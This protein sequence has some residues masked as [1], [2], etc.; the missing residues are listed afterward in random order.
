MLIGL[1]TSRVIL[2]TLGIEDF[3]LYN[4]VG[5][6]VMM[7]S[8]FNAAMSSASARFITYELGVGNQD[9]LKRIF[10][11]SSTLHFL[12]AIICVILLE[13]IGVWFLNHKMNIIPNRM[14]AAN[15]VFQFATLTFFIT[16]VSVPYNAE[17]IAHEKMNAFAYISILEVLLKL[18]IIFVLNWI[19][20]DKLKLYA[21]LIFLVSLFLR[22]I[23]TWYCRK[24]FDECRK[25]RIVFDKNL[26]KKI[27]GYVGWSLF[28]NLSHV[29]YLQGLN[30]I[31]N[32]FFGVT[33]NAARGIS[34]QV[35]SAL[36]QFV[37]SFQMAA[38]P[39]I[40]KYYARNK[41]E[42]MFKLVF[43]SSK[44][45]YFMLLLLS[46]PLFFFMD[47]V[48]QLWL[49]NVPEYTVSFCQLTLIITL[50]NIITLPCH[51]IVQATGK[52]K[53]SSL[54]QGIINLL[55]LPIS[56]VLLRL[57]YLPETVLYVNIFIYVVDLFLRQ[58]I[59]KSL[60]N[61]SVFQFF[62]KVLLPIL[63]VTIITISICYF[64]NAYL[65]RNFL[66]L[67]FFSMFS[68]LQIC[69]TIFFVGINKQERQ[70]I[71]QKIR[72]F[73]VKKFLK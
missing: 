16:V 63:I 4:V 49:K 3:G 23:Y 34:V 42:D 36:M 60:V 41:H 38:N 44:F 72:Q 52:L 21:V 48:L 46:M 43:R 19:A 40:I 24:H 14:E 56:Y 59:V 58:Y 35:Q 67:L 29:S 1:Y 64:L 31:L 17:I 20:F 2:D 45:S 5:G 39:Q 12:I 69:A 62:V 68:T 9:S 7:L 26:F 73:S 65:E 6:L 54:L 50:I 71:I 61:F 33:V 37:S 51:T 18:F 30:I 15:W 66:G 28:S 8:F 11:V 70:F 13:I 57:D 55:I 27:F 53:R 47:V 10:S 25:F 32:L 22:M